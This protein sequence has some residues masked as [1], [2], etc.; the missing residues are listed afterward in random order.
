MFTHYQSIFLSFPQIIQQ[1]RYDALV[2]T[3]YAVSLQL[4]YDLRYHFQQNHFDA[5]CTT[6][7]KSFVKI[8]VTINNI[9]YVPFT[10]K[11]Y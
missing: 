11:P 6:T 1:Q 8:A 5:L 10:D 3:V 7:I 4:V 2:S 9:K